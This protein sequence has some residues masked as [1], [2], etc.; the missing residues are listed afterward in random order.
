MSSL[1]VCLFSRSSSLKARFRDSLLASGLPYDLTIIDD[2]AKFDIFLTS[3]QNATCFFDQELISTLSISNQFR[4]SDFIKSK[5]ILID[6]SGKLENDGWYD[7]FDEHCLKHGRI[8]QIL[9]QH[10]HKYELETKLS[11]MESDLNQYKAIT[12]AITNLADCITFVLDPEFNLLFAN[13]EFVKAIRSNL[14]IE[15]KVGSNYLE[16]PFKTEQIVRIKE[17]TQIALKGKRHKT[18]NFYPSKSGAITAYKTEFIPVFHKNEIIGVAVVAQ[19]VT[20]HNLQQD[21]IS[22]RSEEMANN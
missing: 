2:I 12:A 10:R 16:I 3:N 4:I 17:Y 1:L 8:K 22:S 21:M 11:K 6:L 9:L 19:H 7:T 20:E 15:I 18:E 5:Y 13:Q 14:N